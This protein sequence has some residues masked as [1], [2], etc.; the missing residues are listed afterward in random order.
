MVMLP[1]T[2]MIHNHSKPPKFLHFALPFAS[3]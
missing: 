2:L 1:M 3:S